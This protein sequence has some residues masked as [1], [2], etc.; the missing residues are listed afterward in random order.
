MD[1]ARF[2]GLA[3]LL[4][5]AGS[6]RAG[7][8]AA[9]GLV[10]GAVAGLAAAETDAKKGTGGPSAQGPCGDGSVKQ[11]RCTRNRQCCTN[12]CERNVKNKDKKGRCRCK[13][14]GE[15]CTEDRNCCVRGGQ[16]MSCIDGICADQTCT[17]PQFCADDIECC[18]GQVCTGEVGT[19]TTPCSPTTCPNGCCSGTDCIPF[20]D[21]PESYGDCGTGG[22][23]CTQCAGACAGGVCTPGVPTGS[24]CTQGGLVCADFQANCMTYADGSGGPA[25]TYCLIQSGMS[26]TAPEECA[27]NCCNSFVCCMN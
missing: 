27:G 25:G 23:A 6:R 9:L 26:C 20:A 24:A 1:D 11:N 7:V 14:R 15:A 19:C 21:Q 12:I 17:P 5:K 2:D 8:R 16:Q 3:R 4:A 13:K 22:A 10:A 18:P